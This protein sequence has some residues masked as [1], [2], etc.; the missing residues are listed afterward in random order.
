[1]KQRF[2][3]LIPSAHFLPHTSTSIS[4]PAPLV[5]DLLLD[6]EKY[7]E[8]NTFTPNVELRPSSNKPSSASA[9]KPTFNTNKKL[10][11]GARIVLKVR[12][13]ILG[14]TLPYPSAEEVVVLQRPDSD[15]DDA[16]AD[17]DPLPQLETDARLG[18]G[19][20]YSPS[21]YNLSK[22]VAAAVPEVP[23]EPVP[24]LPPGLVPAA[25]SSSP[26][27]AASAPTPTP[28]PASQNRIQNQQGPRI[29]KVEWIQTSMPRFL[30]RAR[31]VNI[32]EEQED[33]SCVY[34]TYEAFEGPCAYA[35]RLFVGKG[36]Q[37]GLEAWAQGL[38]DRAEKVHAAGEKQ[39]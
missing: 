8:W 28:T 13:P 3:P 34:K 10:T 31:R 23:R 4:A 24:P 25:T 35:V 17:I 14:R 11:L 38:R 16:D 20:W 7:P 18:Y 9:T 30:L 15:D 36:V 5:F 12:I 6:I 19:P 22:M 37:A 33:G 21:E 32:V 39:G 2:P 27:A 26:T 1:M 29:W